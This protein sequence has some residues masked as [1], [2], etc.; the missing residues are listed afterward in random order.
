[1]VRNIFTLVNQYFCIQLPHISHSIQFP[2]SKVFKT[3]EIYARYKLILEEKEG[4]EGDENA[5]R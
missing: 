5:F 4:F 2:G 1:M 3:Y